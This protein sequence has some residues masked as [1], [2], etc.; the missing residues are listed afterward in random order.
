[1]A[2]GLHR[3]FKNSISA[4]R[5][6]TARPVESLE[7]R[8]LLAADLVA[9][10][11]ADSL[12]AL[13]HESVVA[14]WTDNVKSLEATASGEPKLALGQI[15]GR[16][17]IAFDTSDGDDGLK[18]RPQDSPLT[19]LSDFT[20]MVTFATESQSLIGEQGDWFDNTGLVDANA[21]GFS[22][23]WGISINAAGQL[24]VGLGGGFGVAPTT[25]Y[26]TATGLNDGAE[27]TVAFVRQGSEIS[28]Y[29]DELAADS[30]ADAPDAAVAPLAIGIGQ[31]GTG[32]HRFSGH[33][34]EVRLYSGAMDAAE[35]ANSIAAV[36]SY[37]NN[38][39]PVGVP[40][41]YT[42]AEDTLIF[43]VSAA[44]GVLANDTDAEGDALT[45]SIVSEPSN[46]TLQLRD[47]GSFIYDSNQDFFGVE[48]FSYVAN[49][50][51]SSEPTTVTIN[52]TPVYDAVSPIGESY[53]SLP[54]S[55]LSID[56]ANGVLANDSN[57]DNADLTAELVTNVS[58]GSLTLNGDGSF[59]YDPQGFAGETSFSYRIDD[60]TNK[61]STVTTTL[62][63][64]TP[65]ELNDDTYSVT[66]DVDAV[67]AA[68]MGVLA[69]DL[70]ADGDMLTATVT[71]DTSHGTLTL[72]ANGS[73]TYS[74]A[75]NYFGDDE[76]T[77][78][79]SD[80]VD[81]IDGGVVRL[82][83]DSVNDPPVV[84]QD[85]YL[86]LP[87][88]TIDIA[89]AVGVLA[90]DMDIEGAELQA[91]LVQ[92]ASNGT[93]GF[94][95]DGSFSYAPNAGFTGV[96]SFQYVATDGTIDSEPATVQISV[97]SQPI[98][99]NELLVANAG[100]LTTRVRATAEDSYR[101]SE[102][103][104]FDWIELKNPLTS[105]LSLNGF[106]LTDDSDDLSK[107]A[108][109]NGMTIEPG[110]HLLF[111]ASGLNITDAALDEREI[112]HTNFKLSSPG[113]YTAIVGPGEV[114][115]FDVSYPR[116]LPDVSYGVN[117]AGDLRYFTSP[118]PGQPN[119]GDE[120]PATV[121]DTTFSV[122]RGFYSD[123]QSVAITTLTENADI[124]FTL[125][126]S[127]P[128]PQNPTAQKYAQPVSIETTSV[129]RAAAF[130]EGLL[131]SN[132]DTQ[133][134]VFINDVV[135]QGNEPNGYP[136]EWK[137]RQ[138][139]GTLPADYEVDPEIT[140]H[141]NYKD[142]FDD[143]LL[144]VPTISVVTDIDNLFD[145]DT[146]IYQNPMESGV[147]WERPASVE[148]IHPDGTV[149]FQVNAGLRIQGGAS[150]EPRK[151][152][153]HSFR[154]LFKDIYGTPDLEYPL[155][156]AEAVDEFD[157]I[158][159]RAG[160]NQSYIHHNTF[161]GNNRGRAQYVRDQ[162]AKDAQQAMG[163][164]AAH[165]IYAHLYINGM[166]WGLYN[167]TERP[168]DDFGASYFGGEKEEY[169]VYNSGELLDGTGDA[170]DAMFDVV[171]NRDLSDD[172]KYDALLPMLDMDA[173]IDYMLLNHY[174]ANAD[175]DDH[176][177][178]SMRR[179]TDDG[180]WYFFMWDSEFMFIGENDNTIRVSD[181]PRYP[182]RIMRELTDSVEF[183]MR[184]ADRIQLHM[185]NDGALTPENSIDRW[186]ARSSQITDAII[187]ESARWGDYRRDVDPNS[188]P[189]GVPFELLE[190]DVQWVRER[191]RL[192]NDY[193]PG[194]TQTVIEQYRDRDLF[195]TIEAPIFNQRGGTV[196][197]GT[198]ITLQAAEGAKIYY[199]LD[200]TDPR[201]VGGDVH[202]NAIEYAG[203][204]EL[205]A[206][207][208]ITVRALSGDGEW[209]AVDS[210][211]F[212]FETVSA[213]KDSLRISEIHYHPASPSEAEASAGFDNDDDF[214]FIKLVNVSN[215]RIDL[216]SVE[217]QRL[218]IGDGRQGVAFRFGNSEVAR[219]NPG[220]AVFV[221]ED[222][223]AFQA[224]FGTSSTVVG[225]W[226]G[227]LNNAGETITLVAGEQLIH[228]FAYSDQWYPTTDGDGFTLQ[229]ANPE[230]DDLDSWGTKE[231]WIASSNVGGSA[232]MS[233]I[234]GDS[235]QDGIFNSSDLVLVFQA[236]EYEDDI[237]GN[238]TFAEGDWDGDG[239]FTTKDFVFA[240]RAGAYSR[241]ARP[242][243][244]TK[245]IDLIFERIEKYEEKKEKVGQPKIGLVD[246]IDHDPF[247]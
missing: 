195:P 21:L 132:V 198:S 66:E 128:S 38:T 112:L 119:A 239:D 164:N 245:T 125:D 17:A 211:L 36:K 190:R 79:I 145:P 194:R 230:S 65:P 29:V 89:A 229:H 101:R 121:A 87:D 93:I 167:P 19:G 127:E 32:K 209:S 192:L 208:K 24:A 142:L 217:L 99:I 14:A 137:N 179:R 196:Q 158:I 224:R 175:W 216:T 74:P 48:T 114:V 73:F 4:L 183:K 98:L 84:Q 103:E 126:G 143:A 55:V 8:M 178:Y 225:P 35:A 50:L 15:G 221:A 185:Y 188:Y 223:A 102:E 173:Y 111:F 105:P 116:Q 67:V 3:R 44:N 182:A 151:S 149:G 106:Y 144:Q 80:G 139:N 60:G 130:K 30:R 69:N 34:A 129:L 110:G 247:I 16:S 86:T 197:P 26:S 244:P 85:S 47:D 108:I 41:S 62:V 241:E 23:D 246:T 56:A 25:L 214:E 227:G 207:T 242:A 71:S 28:L 37:Y 186:N 212:L 39:A 83:I 204:V 117:G 109:P 148:L 76:F 177:W 31:L 136:A 180:K 22:A 122:D 134:Y 118:T 155:F 228:Q 206:E 174:G 154:L 189:A 46:G 10:W 18:L 13:P 123:T 63:L 7:A 6:Q 238:S 113:E 94:N 147:E 171:L 107:W 187:G 68:D 235:N 184:L 59:S 159:L 210:A 95:V 52:V 96:D 160:F 226:A 120:F 193:F 213:S 165:N 133:T 236:G 140:Q 191:N 75:P 5:R 61:S 64:N 51:Q 181:G 141:P 1:M 91:S 54:S 163:W 176:N 215:E 40:D 200:G 104:S 243:L 168:T 11:R 157:T 43:A 72:N 27:H 202:A 161:L 169:D 81:S 203:P 77:Y 240:F 153:K 12:D 234:P 9:H 222:V 219:L 57:P 33:I 232:A 138:G 115:L 58:Q 42:V 231:G 100:S 49:D 92:G 90:N 97:E 152:P 220:E 156:G 70:D 170:W 237:A 88:Q 201:V 124:Y 146:G 135:N 131:P 162:W 166:Y 172:Q 53:Q 150:R 2:F 45:A 20:V 82:T 218:A 233:L 199:T 78:S 205:T